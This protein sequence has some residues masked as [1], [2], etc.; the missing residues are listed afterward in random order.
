MKNLKISKQEQIEELKMD[1]QYQVAILANGWHDT[2]ME[3]Y[4]AQAE[5]E[6]LEQKLRNLKK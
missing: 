1:I 5:L 6:Q 2:Q 3:K 4:E